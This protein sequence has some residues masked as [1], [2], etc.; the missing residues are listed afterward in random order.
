MPPVHPSTQPT[1]ALAAVDFHSRVGGYGACVVLA[2]SQGG[3]LFGGYNPL[4]F[5][6]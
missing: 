4:G 2:R 5:E 6:G 1:H 3:A